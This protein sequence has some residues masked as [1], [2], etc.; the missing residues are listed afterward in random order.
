MTNFVLWSLYRL[1][2]YMSTIKSYK[3]AL[4]DKRKVIIYA[5]L[6]LYMEV[7]YACMG[8]DTRGTQLHRCTFK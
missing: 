1:S 7:R 8:I 6:G 2:G 3:T 4:Y 5:I